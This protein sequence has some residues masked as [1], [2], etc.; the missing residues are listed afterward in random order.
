M[1]WQALKFSLW[2][3][4]L[5]ICSPIENLYEI[6][7]N[8]NDIGLILLVIRAHRAHPSHPVK[9]RMPSHANMSL[10]SEEIELPLSL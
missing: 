1:P 10:K 4:S 8:M 9:G 5:M 6:Y 2:G 3:L 7:R